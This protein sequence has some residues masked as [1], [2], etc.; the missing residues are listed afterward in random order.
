MVAISFSNNLAAQCSYR[1]IF[2]FGMIVASVLL[3][4]A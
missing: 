4:L 2:G 3:G 1:F